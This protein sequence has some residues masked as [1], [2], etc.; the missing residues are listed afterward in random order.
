M[1]GYE[2]VLGRRLFKIRA[3]DS[4]GSCGKSLAHVWMSHHLASELRAPDLVQQAPRACATCIRGPKRLRNDFA[5]GVAQ[6]APDKREAISGKLH[7]QYKTVDMLR[8]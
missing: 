8:G 2:P 5:F 6:Q 3:L 4:P 7:I 1:D